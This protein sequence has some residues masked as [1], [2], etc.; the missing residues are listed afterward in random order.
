MYVAGTRRQVVDERAGG[1]SMPRDPELSVVVP[2]YD[3]P[4]IIQALLD[5]LARQTLAPDRFEVVTVD[6]GSTTPVRPRTSQLAYPLTLLRQDNAGPGAARNLAFEHC[7]APLA[8]ILNDDA[9]PADDLL[10]RHLAIH[11]E[12]PAR[13]AVLG[14]FTFTPNA[15]ASPFVQLL[16]TSDLLFDFPRLRH[17]AT[18]DWRFF[19]T[20][21]ISLPLAP[22]QQV[23]GFDAETFPGPLM[24]D[25]DLGYRLGQQGWRVLYRGDARCG[26]EHRLTAQSYLERIRLYGKY[27]VR[28]WRK[29]DDPGVL[30]VANADQIGPA[31]QRAQ[32]Q[33]EALRE[34]L[35][36]ALE[37]LDEFERTHAGREVPP[38]TLQDV[39]R[40]VSAVRAVPMGRGIALGLHCLLYTS[41]SPRDPE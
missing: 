25:V 29:Y 30:G 27:L 9:V 39:G 36:R 14:T 21:N 13:T 16:A 31:L 24:E 18:L 37:R 20:C 17:G 40:V 6:D 23:G 19:W 34:T 28:M 38:T 15:L 26:H 10:E 41:P 35:P 32:L 3:R 12:S 8:L 4:E 1:T 11:R 7:R 2:T 33:Y 5:R 22:I